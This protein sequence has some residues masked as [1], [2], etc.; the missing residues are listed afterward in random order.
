MNI[1]IQ[2]RLCLAILLALPLTVDAQWSELQIGA[3]LQSVQGDAK[4]LLQGQEVV[5]TSLTVSLQ[6]RSSKSSR[7]SAGLG[8]TAYSIG[9]DYSS[10]KDWLKGHFAD[11]FGMSTELTSRY[12]LFRKVDFRFMRNDWFYYIEAGAAMHLFRYRTTFY[13]Y[14]KVGE[15]I[16][17]DDL[18]YTNSTALAGQ[19][20]TGVNYQVSRK[21]GYFSR[22]A[23]QIT[24][25]DLLDG[26][27]GITNTKDHLIR[28]EIG[29]YFSF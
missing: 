23:W 6:M 10:T 2:F 19:L 28:F 1:L 7:I 15:I 4:K 12:Y 13:P 24:T 16:G 27:V 8:V 9:G 3:G 17:R 11:G 29:V 26:L 18:P 20:A 14:E 22:L 21:F 25:S 5:N